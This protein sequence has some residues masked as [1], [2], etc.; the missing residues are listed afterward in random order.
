MI[1]GGAWLLRENG[2]LLGR[3]ADGPLDGGFGIGS[4]YVR[5]GETTYLV[6]ILEG[7][8]G[9]ELESIRPS[10]ISPGLEIV[11]PVLFDRE[12]SGGI[13]SIKRWPPRAAAAPSPPARGSTSG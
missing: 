2:I 13:T 4:G 11:G 3:D 9:H 8:S 12:R 7:G 6:D 5:P 10:L 1:G